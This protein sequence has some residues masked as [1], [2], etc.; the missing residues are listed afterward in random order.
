MRQQPAPGMLLNTVVCVKNFGHHLG[1]NREP[2]K[3]ST[4]MGDRTRLHVSITLAATEE[5]GWEW[6]GG[7]MS[8]GKPG[9]QIKRLW[10]TSLVVQ[11]I[12]LRQSERGL[13]K[14]LQ[15]QRISERSEFIKN[16]G[17]R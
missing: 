12:A 6:G 3:L 15:T 9:W 14:N 4:Q 16:K 10:W 5:M 17:Q 11:W 7:G 13:E 2:L 8:R 1:S